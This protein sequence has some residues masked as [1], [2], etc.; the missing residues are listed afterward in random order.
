MKK[1]TSPGDA[2]LPSLSRRTLLG[3]TAA[4]GAL[5]AL[6]VRAQTPAPQ[7]AA[8]AAPAPAAAAARFEL[9]EVTVAELQAR[10]QAGRE[11]ARS[12]TE[13]YLA[14]IRA[15]DR[16]G[17]QP[18]CSVI[19]L[20][21]DALALAEQLDAERKA[22]KVRG[23]LHGIPVL[24]KD[25]IATLDKMQTTA[26]S[27]ALVDAKPLRDAHVA[28]RLRAAG[29]VLLGKTNLSEWANFRSTHSSS[30]WSGRGGQ[31]R[32]PYALDR[33]PSG[34][35]SGSGAAAAAN[36]CAVA[37]GTETDGSIV[38]P[39][40]ANS[41]VGLKPTVGLVSRAGIIPI[42]HT[43]DTAGPM[44]RCVA[45]AAALLSVLAGVD[46]RDKAT[47]ASAGKAHP[48][49][50]K[51]LDPKG[52]EGARIGVPRERFFGYHPDT[53][54]RANEALAVMKAH[55]A[56]IVELKELP[57]AAKLDDAE[58]EV[59]L[60]EFK[61]DLEAYLAE[62]G[63]QSPVRTLADLITFN[64]KNRAKEMPFFGQ[65]LFEQAQKKGPL[66]DP[67]YKKALETCRRNARMLGLDA[68]LKKHRLD[69]L[70]TPTQAPPGPI[71]LVLGD[72]WLGSSSTPAAV[73]GYP[74]ITVPA[75]YVH[76]LPVGVS[77]FGAAWSEPT[78]LKLAYAYEQAS[79]LRRAPTFAASAQLQ[80]GA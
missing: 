13:K 64:D 30:G 6:D 50:T 10:M 22:G 80:P 73:A 65:E 3:A 20:N 71:D 14:R 79:R 77:F 53:D 4:A 45:D 44:A 21:P 27:L 16:T 59:L 42:S 70:V 34:S 69:A 76:G 61:A 7:P 18:L 63:P 23:P 67:R 31:C 29:A 47:A 55:G 38:S 75:G 78:L 8:P 9:E 60:F 11:S 58:F 28:E 39:S 35:S 52:L 15:L 68:V 40:A 57:N 41:L 56:V 48:D 2:S 5:A 12:L 32:N 25:N 46:P 36:F 24:I 26:G 66:S 74:S 19:E 62:L 54:A 49:Y 43:Q 33:T 17:P 1:P 37:V 51:F 72:H